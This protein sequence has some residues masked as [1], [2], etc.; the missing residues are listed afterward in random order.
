MLRLILFLSVIM[1]TFS[2]VKADTIT[3]WQVYYNNELIAVFNNFDTISKN[4][5][6]PIYNKNINK[7]DTFIVHYFE[8]ARK[9][10]YNLQ[11]INQD[12]V[13]YSF[14][15]DKRQSTFIIPINKL[16]YDNKRKFDIYISS[17]K[18]KSKLFEMNLV[19]LSNKCN[20]KQGNSAVKKPKK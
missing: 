17:D 13:F 8:C 4:A 10:D 15:S 1:F 3:N 16:I 9:S 5:I 7:P 2:K 6:Y 12:S 14:P 11:V 18:F 20:F 19:N